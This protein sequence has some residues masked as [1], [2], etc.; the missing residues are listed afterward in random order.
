MPNKVFWR[1]SMSPSSRCQK[2]HKRI[3][4][5]WV[6][7]WC[8]DLSGGLPPLHLWLSTEN[9][10]LNPWRQG[11]RGE[12]RGESCDILEQWKD[13]KTHCRKSRRGRKCEN[14]SWID[15][16]HRVVSLVSFPVTGTQEA[17]HG[18]ADLAGSKKFEPR[19]RGRSTPEDHLDQDSYTPFSATIRATFEH[20]VVFKTLP[21]PSPSLLPEQFFNSSKCIFKQKW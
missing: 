21:P 16:P 14:H 5:F 13:L 19:R 7:T 20:F 10:S 1:T 11:G 17:K 18:C 9:E 6:E 15:I 3:C 12:K 4:D 2:A 8:L